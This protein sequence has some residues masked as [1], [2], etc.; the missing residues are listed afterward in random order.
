MSGWTRR[1]TQG[2]TSH[3]GGDS[4]R[5]SWACWPGAKLDLAKA[6]ATGLVEGERVAMADSSLAQFEGYMAMR[7][8]FD[9]GRFADLDA[10]AAA[11]KKG[12]GETAVFYKPESAFSWTGFAL[13]GVAARY[14]DF[15]RPLYEEAAR[16]ARTQ[17]I[18]ATLRQFRFLKADNATDLSATAPA[19]DASSWRSTDVTVDSWSSLG[20]YAYFGPAWYR[21]SFNV[22]PE[23]ASKPSQIW[24]GGTDGRVRV[25]VDGKEAKFVPSSSV[26][27]P[28]GYV[29]PFTFDAGRLSAGSHVVA[30]LATRTTLNE[31][32]TGGLMG[33]VV[34]NQ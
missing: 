18:V 33:P 32:G 20:L 23:A 25:F 4:P 12:A 30:I 3:R 26:T 8:D 34:V 22:A 24:V 13:E 11:W 31:L 27:A 1:S 28:E 17:S 14:F 5:R 6:A 9:E 10:R 15:S 7:R 16:I 29:T 2:G 21:A 19:F